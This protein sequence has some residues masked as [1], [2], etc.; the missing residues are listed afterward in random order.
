MAFETPV[1][2]SRL[3]N[4]NPFAVPGRCRQITCPAIF[5]T[6]PFRSLAKSA[7]RQISGSWERINFIGCGPTESPVPL[8]SARSHSTGFIGTSGSA[9]SF[10][11]RENK[12]SASRLTSICRADR[13]AGLRDCGFFRLPLSPKTRTFV[14]GCRQDVPAL[15]RQSGAVRRRP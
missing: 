2:S 14:R 15:S 6:V 4:T 7:A 3:T 1:S 13:I 5:T 11:T 8:Y 9:T 10:S 12:S